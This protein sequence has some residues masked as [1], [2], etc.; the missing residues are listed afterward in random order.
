VKNVAERLVVASRIEAVLFAGL[1]ESWNFLG[2]R[3]LETCLG[4]IEI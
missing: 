4:L 2:V 1:R 3:E